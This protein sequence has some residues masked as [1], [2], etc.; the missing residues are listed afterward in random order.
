MNQIINSSD[1]KDKIKFGL[2]GIY[3]FFGEEEYMKQFYLSEIRKSV[4]GGDEDGIFRH[5]KISCIDFDTEKMTD[6]LQTSALGFFEGKTLCELHEIQF[7]SLKESEWKALISM[8][9]DASPDVITVIY[10][11]KD[12]FDE[13]FIPKNPSKALQRLAE[14]AVPVHFPRESDL[15]LAK[16]T[17]RHFIS[18]KLSFEKGVCE[19]MVTRCGRDMFVLSNEIEK[20]SAYVKA[21]GRSTV[22]AE[23][24]KTVCCQNMEINAFDFSNALL[25][26]DTDKAMAILSDMKL[27]KE[28]P[29]MILGSVTKVIADLYTVKTLIDSGLNDREISKELKMHEYKLGIYKR[30]AAKRSAVRLKKLLRFCCDTDVKLKSTS[31]ESYTELDKLVILATMR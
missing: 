17:S 26:S 24:V 22:T 21:C 30:S 3:F 4:F 8:L 27:R 5:K 10:T 29:V 15:K 23:D 7:S 1:L 11:V 20:V 2:N 31:L 9:E 12:E 25:E 6:A 16:W 28:K 19:L 18:E 14:V 13:G